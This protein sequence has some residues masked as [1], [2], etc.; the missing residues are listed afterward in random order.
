MDVLAGGG[1]EFAEKYLCLVCTR[2]IDNA[3]QLMCCGLR[4]CG[5]CF[6]STTTILCPNRRCRREVKENGVSKDW[7]ILN[8]VVIICTYFLSVFSRQSFSEGM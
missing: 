6:S 1:D 8:V 2:V 4:L 3:I 5:P 7:L